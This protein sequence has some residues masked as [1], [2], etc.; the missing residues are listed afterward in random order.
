LVLHHQLQ[1]LELVFLS[2]KIYY[3]SDAF[4]FNYAK[5]FILLCALV[6]FFYRNKLK[7]FNALSLPYFLLLV[8]MG[9]CIGYYLVKH[10]TTKQ[11]SNFYIYF[12]HPLQILFYI[13]FISIKVINKTKIALSLIGLFLLLFVITTRSFSLGGILIA[14]LFLLFVLKLTKDDMVITF[15]KNLYFWICL[16]VALYHTVSFPYY[17]YY[18]TLLAM[19]KDIF[20]LY[21]NIIGHFS[22]SMYLLFIIG[23]IWSKKT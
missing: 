19:H 9:E 23:F 7:S 13:W 14:I 1:V 20:F 2:H 17:T 18:N 10:G 5:Y 8:F 16:G 4:F 22:L 3:M 15:H 11:S 12:L 21:R 6:G